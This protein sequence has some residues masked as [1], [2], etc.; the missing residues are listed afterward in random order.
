MRKLVNQ[1][2]E[3]PVYFR[4]ELEEKTSLVCAV[5][6]VGE[7][8]FIYAGTFFIATPL[9]C[10]VGTKPRGSAQGRP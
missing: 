4:A 6:V 2:R 1:V 10:A 7:E 9:H 3:C 5:S 8:R